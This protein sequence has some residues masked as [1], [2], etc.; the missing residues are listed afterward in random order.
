MYVSSLEGHD[1]GTPVQ[2]NTELSVSHCLYRVSKPFQIS[3]AV[4]MNTTGKLQKGKSSAPCSR[5]TSF[6]DMDVVP[7]FNG[8]PFL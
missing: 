1:P 4:S 6:E 7:H 8:T 5:A 2:I 3:V